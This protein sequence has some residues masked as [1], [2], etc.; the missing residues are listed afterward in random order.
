[1]CA[2]GLFVCA[3]WCLF[4]LFLFGKHDEMEEIYETSDKNYENI[5]VTVIEK[6]ICRKQD[7]CN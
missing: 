3:F 4:L 7:K 6:W 2:V 5:R 1:M